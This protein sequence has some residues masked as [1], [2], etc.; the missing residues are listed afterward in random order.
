[1]NESLHQKCEL[2]AENY[3]LIAKDFKWDLDIMCIVAALSY[4]NSHRKA[5]TAG[6]KACREILAKKEGIFSDLR[7]TTEL[8]LLSKMAVDNNTEAYLDEKG[9]KVYWEL[10]VDTSTINGVSN[11]ISF[12]NSG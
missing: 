8:A 12:F 2:L 6:M 7:S 1:M 3:T 5:D 10:V 9:H 4:T 11:K